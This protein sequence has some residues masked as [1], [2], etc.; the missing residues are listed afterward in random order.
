[1]AVPPRLTGTRNTDAAHAI[2]SMINGPISSH[3]TPNDAGAMRMIASRDGCEIAFATPFSAVGT[4]FND[5]MKP[6]STCSAN[7]YTS[8]A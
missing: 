5:Q 2:R 6:C 4:N 1:M 8:N 7:S 3:N